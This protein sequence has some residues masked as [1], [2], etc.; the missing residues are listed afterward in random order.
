MRGRKRQ[1]EEAVPITWHTYRVAG[2]TMLPAPQSAA[3]STV[4][5]LNPGCNASDDEPQM[6]RF[7]FLLTAHLLSEF[8][9]FQ[10]SNRYLNGEP[11]VKPKPK[12]TDRKKRKLGSDEAIAQAFED[13]DL[14]D[15]ERARLENMQRN[16]AFL[17][18]LG[19]A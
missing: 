4:C 8:S 14:S 5:C 9:P 16:N 15:F 11:V 10:V 19:L 3:C 6:R 17:A 18:S 2:E 12:P 13:E 1:R 7:P